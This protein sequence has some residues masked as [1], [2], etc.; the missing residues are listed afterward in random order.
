MK[1]TGRYH[2]PGG[3]EVFTVKGQPWLAFHYYNADLG[4]APMLQLA[5]IGWTDDG[6]PEVGPLPGQ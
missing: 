3:Q 2:G 1:T 5:P 6:W 4:G